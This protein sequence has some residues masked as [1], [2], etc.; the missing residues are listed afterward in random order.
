MAK[1]FY[2]AFSAIDFIS[3]PKYSFYIKL[4]IDGQTSKGFSAISLKE[5]ATK[6]F[7]KEVVM[8]NHR[9]CLPAL[10]SKMGN[11]F[12]NIEPLQ[13]SLFDLV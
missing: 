12:P 2:P 6:F 4:M 7:N 11:V 8:E 1:E 13:D 9:K 10:V 5:K 3:L